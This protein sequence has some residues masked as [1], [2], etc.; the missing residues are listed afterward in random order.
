[1]KRVFLIFLMILSISILSA[2]NNETNNSTEQEIIT[3]NENITDTENDASELMSFTLE[4]LSQFD[5]RDGRKAYIAVNDNVYD[6]SNSSMWP[7][8]L[9]QNQHQAG[10][11]LSDII[12]SSPHGISVLA[13]IPLI[14]YLVEE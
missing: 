12:N 1:M 5:G 4:E 6:V 8:G 13:N 10:Q 2:C 3:D 7:N 11:D 9:H 14:G